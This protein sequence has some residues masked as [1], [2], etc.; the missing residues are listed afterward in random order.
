MDDETPIVTPLLDPNAFQ[1]NETLLLLSFAVGVGLLILIAWIQDWYE[2]LSA[3]RIAR[4][5]NW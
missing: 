2:R 4:R 5:R 3:R 1:F